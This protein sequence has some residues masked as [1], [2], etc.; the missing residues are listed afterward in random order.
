MTGRGY[1]EQWV[2]YRIPHIWFHTFGE[3]LSRPRPQSFSQKP[4][5]VAEHV[6]SVKVSGDKQ[7]TYLACAWGP[8]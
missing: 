3:S 5:D 7:G 4:V 6:V 2:P 8:E 1:C